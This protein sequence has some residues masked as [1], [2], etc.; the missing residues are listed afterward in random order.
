MK[1]AK[2]LT[3]P[4]CGANISSV[5]ISNPT[6]ICPQCKQVVS[7]PLY[8]QET[9]IAVNVIPQDY[10]RKQFLLKIVEDLENDKKV[11]PQTIDQIPDAEIHMFYLLVY[12]FDCTYN[13]P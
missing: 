8:E 2:S 9:D 3:C 12:Y 5:E 7:N 1:K 11:A 13:A 4:N 10:D 6:V